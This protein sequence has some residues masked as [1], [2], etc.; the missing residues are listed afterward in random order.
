MDNKLFHR[1]RE[2][3]RER[4]REKERERKRE[5]GTG[6]RYSYTHILNVQ[7]TF[8]VSLN[9]TEYPLDRLEGVLREYVIQ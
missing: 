2:R 8:I 9:D 4:K 1:K 5:R 7:S 3:E 6:K